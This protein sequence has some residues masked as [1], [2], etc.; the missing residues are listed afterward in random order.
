VRWIDWLLVLFLSFIYFIFGWSLN[1]LNHTPAL[2][3]FRYLLDRASHFCSGPASDCNPPTY[4]LPITWDN[5]CV[6]PRPACWA[7][8][9]P[10]A[11]PEPTRSSDL[12]LQSSWH[13][14]QELPHT[15][16]CL[17]C[18]Q[19][20]GQSPPPERNRKAFALVSTKLQTYLV[21]LVSKEGGMSYYITNTL[22]FW[23]LYLRHLDSFDS[24]FNV[25]GFLGSYVFSVTDCNR[26]FLEGIWWD[27]WRGPWNRN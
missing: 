4:G 27:C 20:W 26:L 25:T 2:F 8:F 5:L 17:P 10:R 23:E 6:P 18:M 3:A 11:G 13:Y 1:H 24:S 9:L 21:T 19:L 16:T 14:R 22:I 15:H 7:S 12:P